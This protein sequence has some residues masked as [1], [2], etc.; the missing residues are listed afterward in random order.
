MTFTFAAIFNLHVQYMSFLWCDG[1]TLV[2]LNTVLLFVKIVAACICQLVFLALYLVNKE[3][4]TAMAV[5]VYISTILNKALGE[6][7]SLA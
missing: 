5:T 4:F 1:L 7:G 2:D 3:W 6:T